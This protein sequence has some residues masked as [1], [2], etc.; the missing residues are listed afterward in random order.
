MTRECPK[1][2]HIP[3]SSPQAAE[4]CGE[5]LRERAFQSTGFHQGQ[6]L[7]ESRAELERGGGPEAVVRRAIQ[8]SEKA[9]QQ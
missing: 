3:A 7:A 9:G 2:K 4:D 5:I 8:R 1:A 6:H